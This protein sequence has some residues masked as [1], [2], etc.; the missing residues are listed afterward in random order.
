MIDKEVDNLTKQEKEAMLLKLRKRVDFFD[1]LLVFL[2]N[3][4]TKTTVLI[5]RVKLSL[6]LPT[7]NPERERDVM[8]RIYVHNKGPLT[9]ESLERIYERILDESRA[10]QKL[11]SPKLFS[12][13]KN[14]K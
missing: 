11:E 8:R 7:Y 12:K 3:K 9:E 4:R 10:T 14:E 5:G 2:L 13:D 6:N 1:R